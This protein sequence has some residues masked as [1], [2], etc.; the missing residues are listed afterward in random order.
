MDSAKPTSEIPLGSES[1]KPIISQQEETNRNTTKASSLLLGMQQQQQQQQPPAQSMQ[2]Q[3]P[4][5]QPQQQP[6]EDPVTAAALALALSTSTGA[7]AAA[8]V[9]SNPLLLHNLI[10]PSLQPSAL[11]PSL[12]GTPGHPSALI[13]S[14]HQQQQQQHQQAVALATLAGS[15]NPHHPSSS[16]QQ[17]AAST[18]AASTMAANTAA[19]LLPIV[20][21]PQTTTIPLT[22]Q[23]RPLTP[24]IYNGVN[25]NYPGLRVLNNSPPMFCVDN[26]LTPFEC[27]FLVQVAQDS[28]GPAPVVGKGAGE[29]SPSRTSS[30]CY[31]AREDLPDLL[32]KVSLLTGKSMDCIELPQVGRYFPSQQY[33][34][35]F[36]AF[37]L[38]NEDGLRFAANGGQRTVTVLIYLN[39]CEKGGATRF[40]ALNLEVQ[41]RRGMALVFFP[42]TVDGLL[43]KMALHAALP[44]IDTK[45]VSQCW[46]RQST[47]NGQPSKRLPAPLGV[48]FALDE[49]S[50]GAFV[51]QPLPAQLQQV[52]LQQQQQQ[53]AVLQQ[54]QQQKAQSFGFPPQRF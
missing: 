25:P 35:H 18:M 27:D 9:A 44:A 34:Q 29:I 21:P 23:D 43:D 50:N 54:Q 51:N 26:F 47:Y 3:P 1:K 15:L 30:T 38:G 7:A 20:A 6:P 24:P 19:A 49:N 45:Y 17:L 22:V 10:P 31:L 53:Q 41:P 28:F 12:N 11:A 40:P 4:Q 36:D 33:L 39:D 8:A 5:Q 52:A 48:P 14:N 46:I 32:R 13:P 16:Q 42:A 37:D 2:Q